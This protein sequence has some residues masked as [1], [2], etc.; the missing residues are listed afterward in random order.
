METDGLPRQARDRHTRTI[1][2]KKRGCRFAHRAGSPPHGARHRG[3][4]HVAHTTG[5]QRRLQR[6]SAELSLLQQKLA[7]RHH[8]QKKRKEKTGDALPVGHFGRGPTAEVGMQRPA[9]HALCL[10]FCPMSVPSLSWEMVGFLVQHGAK[11]GVFRAPHLQAT[12]HVGC[13]I[14]GRVVSRHRAPHLN[15]NIYII[16]IMHN[17]DT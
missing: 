11:K 1:E 15:V 4:C 7:N 2:R 10:N 9:K 6:S 17:N 16:M 12:E 14:E 13:L 8:Q 5:V 3:T